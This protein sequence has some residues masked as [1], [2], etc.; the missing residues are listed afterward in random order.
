MLCLYLIFLVL[1]VIEFFTGQRVTG[2]PVDN[3]KLKI[4]EKEF[5]ET[6]FKIWMFQ[7]LNRLK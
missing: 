4:E 1:N 2:M 6:E 5:N 3:P 7:T